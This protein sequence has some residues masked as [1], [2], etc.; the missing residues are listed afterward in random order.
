MGRNKNEHANG[1]KSRFKL[2]QAIRDLFRVLGYSR[3]SALVLFGGFLVFLFPGQGQEIV[4]ST[5]DNN[6]H[7]IFMMVAVVIAASN[8]WYWSRTVLSREFARS[9]DNDIIRIDDLRAVSDDNVADLARAWRTQKFIG[10]LT[11]NDF[12]RARVGIWLTGLVNHIPRLLAIAVFV[13]AAY[14]YYQ[15]GSNHQGDFSWIKMSIIIGV[16]IVFYLFLAYRRRLL[17]EFGQRAPIASDSRAHIWAIILIAVFLSVPFIIDGQS[18]M[19]ISEFLGAGA[20]VFLAIA[21][22][23]PVGSYLV[24]LS[25][26]RGFP[27][28]G[29]LILVAAI[30]TA[31]PNLPSLFPKLP[32]DW[33]KRF[34]NHDIR[35]AN[36]LQFDKS[37]DRP[38]LQ[39]AFDAWY[40][41]ARANWQE[42][43]PVPMVTVATAGGGLPAAQW[44]TTILGALEDQSKNRFSNYVFAISGVSGGSL[45]AAVYAAEVAERSQTGLT[46]S[47]PTD[48]K[49]SIECISRQMLSQDFLAP[50]AFGLL[51]YDVFRHINYLLP[52]TKATGLVD[53]PD[54][55]AL[56]EMAWE[57]GWQHA[58]GETTIEFADSFLSYRKNNSKWQPMLLLNAT[59]QETGRRAI[60]SHIDFSERDILDALDLFDNSNKNHNQGDIQNWCNASD[61]PLSTAA[62]NSARF[63]YVSPAGQIPADPI[64]I[65]AEKNGQC[66]L[67]QGHLIDGGYFENN[68]A[69][70]AWDLLEA[71]SKLDNGEEKVAPIIIQIVSNPD[72]DNWLED[73]NAPSTKESYGTLNELIAPLRGIFET[74]SARGKVAT[75]RLQNLAKNCSDKCG[76]LFV[77]SS[78][79][80]FQMTKGTTAKG[81][82]VG[83]SLSTKSTT[84]ICQMIKTT[85]TSNEQSNNGKQKIGNISDVLVKKNIMSFERLTSRLNMKAATLNTLYCDPKIWKD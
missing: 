18:G 2:S 38:N 50:N 36:G 15:Q 25:H 61:V 52:L 65:E 46:I 21:L 5:N 32:L 20:I 67:L 49:Q 27:I 29:T 17:E 23:I 63:P 28:I 54:R 47:D 85:D 43:G 80:L 37:L 39:A 11:R 82:G 13:I 31:L 24:V 33:A 8:A 64:H 48:C 41:Q 19:R 60:A 34:E 62:H 73:S 56:L 22:L 79:F 74:R 6:L 35:T 77:D 14:G 10:G 40:V 69:A 9:K 7:F 72:E 1:R 45:G 53:R 71:L 81:P 4:S 76:N 84:D 51:Y 83:W 3:F 59:H 57:K 78:Y 68:G 75:L 26:D 70:T 44:T 30:V 12:E 66:N 58:H 55:G 42:D 16:G